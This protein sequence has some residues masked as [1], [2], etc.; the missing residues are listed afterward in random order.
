MIVSKLKKKVVIIGAGFGGLQVIKSLAN[1]R[2]YDIVVVDKKITIYSNH[3]YTKLPQ[4]YCHRQTSQSQHG[5]S[6]RNIKM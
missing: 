1:H 3:F 2:D 4:Q 6:L 5:R